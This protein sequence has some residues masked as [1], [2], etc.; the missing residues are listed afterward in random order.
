MCVDSSLH[1]PSRL[2]NPAARPP[3]THR[4]RVLLL[5]APNR[6]RLRPPGRRMSC[7]AALMCTCARKT[8]ALVYVTV[9]GRGGATHFCICT[10]SCAAQTGVGA[11]HRIPRVR[12]AAFT[13]VSTHAPTRVTAARR[14]RRHPARRPRPHLVP[15]LHPPCPPCPPHRCHQLPVSLSPGVALQAARAALVSV[16]RVSVRAA[17]PTTLPHAT[18]TAT[19]A[20]L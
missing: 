12:K 8:P 1:P 18:M 14:H 10:E 20:I 3:P 4:L 6:P 11:R 9:E 5:P 2:T 16:S 13:C 15:L 17:L 19:A 7:G